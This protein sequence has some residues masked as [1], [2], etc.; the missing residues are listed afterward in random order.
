VVTLVHGAYGNNIGPFSGKEDAPNVTEGVFSFNADEELVKGYS[1]KYKPGFAG[2]DIIGYS[3]DELQ[4]SSKFVPSQVEVEYLYSQI[5]LDN[6]KYLNNPV[7]KN[8]AKTKRNSPHRNYTPT[9]IF[10]V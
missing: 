1:P 7:T 5:N 4:L 8:T 3:L 2:G 6:K 9:C 10:I